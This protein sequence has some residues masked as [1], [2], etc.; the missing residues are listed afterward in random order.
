MLTIAKETDDPACWMGGKLWIR[1]D[2]L[3]HGNNHSL[4]ILWLE[5]DGSTEPVARE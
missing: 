2:A 3:Y 4:V 1:E 5:Y